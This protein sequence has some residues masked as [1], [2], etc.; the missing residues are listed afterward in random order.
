MKLALSAF[1]RHEMEP[2]LP[3]DVEATWFQTVDE[4]VEAVKGAEVAELDLLCGPDEFTRILEAGGN[5]KWVSCCFAGVD[6][7]PTDYIEQRG[8][9]FTNGAGVTA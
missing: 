6:R 4:A 5:L 8:L 2:R 9:L 1:W 3:A 7:Y